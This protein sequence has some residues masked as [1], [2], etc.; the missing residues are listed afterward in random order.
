MRLPQK[1]KPGD[2]IM[3]EDW[4]LLLDAIGAV[5]GL[6][7]YVLYIRRAEVKGSRFMRRVREIP[8]KI[9]GLRAKPT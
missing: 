4:N 6:G 2:P 3:A 1:K 5:I 8:S 9:K 7:A